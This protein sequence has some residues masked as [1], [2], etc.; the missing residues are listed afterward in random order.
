MPRPRFEKLSPERREQMLEVAAQEF[1]RHGYDGASLNHIL[2]TAGV[3]K[4]AAYYYFDD[5]ADLFATVVAHYTAHLAADTGFDFADLDAAHFWPAIE[6]LYRQVIDH[7]AEAPWMLGVAR[8]VWRLSTEARGQR[9][10][11]ALF[12]RSQRLL[13][14]VIRRG[15]RVGAVRT[16]LPADLLIALLVGI[17]GAWD[18]WLLGAMDRLPAKETR[19]IAARILPA[20]RRLFEPTRRGRR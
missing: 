14:S 16:D 8:A 2:E 20:V 5:K 4:G 11:G 3:S 7:V 9:K 12:D 13:E 6:E 17:D 1:S 15:Q 18:R 19:A 10:L